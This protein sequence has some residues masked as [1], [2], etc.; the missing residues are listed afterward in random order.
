MIQYLLDS[1]PG[2]EAQRTEETM[3]K[4]VMEEA[5]IQDMAA[6]VMITLAEEVSTIY[7]RFAIS[8]H[9]LFSWWD[10]IWRSL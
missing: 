2:R 5:R 1:N 4:E 3:T 9:T 7:D 6:M 8:E 10:S